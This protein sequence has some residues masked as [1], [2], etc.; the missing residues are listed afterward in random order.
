M[1]SSKRSTSARVV[2]LAL[3]QRR[4]LDGEVD[5]EGRLD[6]GRARRG[7]RRSSFQSATDRRPA[8]R[9]SCARDPPARRPPP[10]SGRVGLR[11]CTGVA[12]AGLAERLEERA[13]APT[14]GARSIVLALVR[15]R[16]RARR[17]SWPSCDEQLLGERHQVVVVGVGLVELEH[18]ELGVVL[19]RDPLVAEVAV[20]LVDALEAADDQALQVQLG[21]DAQ[22]EVHVE[23][24]VVGDEGPRRGAAGDRL[25]HRRLDLEEAARVEE[26]RGWPG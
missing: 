7:C 16:R 22:V 24:V 9:R 15:Q 11:A 19:R 20:D 5:D 26:A 8:A 17:I 10:A 4:E 14:G 1:K 21:R 18:R 2:P 25:H 23:R 6:Q 12:R 3:G 13:G